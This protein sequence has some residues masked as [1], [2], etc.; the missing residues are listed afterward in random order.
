MKLKR[1]IPD[2]QHHQK[3]TKILIPK[4]NLKKEWEVRA[5][6]KNNNRQPSRIAR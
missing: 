4:Q 1:K 2:S 3:E 5:P 6:M